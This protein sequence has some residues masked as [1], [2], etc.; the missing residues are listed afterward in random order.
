MIE[1]TAVEV[2]GEPT[3]AHKEL[4]GAF[5]KWCTEPDWCQGSLHDGEYFNNGS[6]NAGAFL[7]DTQYTSVPD[8]LQHLTDRAIRRVPMRAEIKSELKEIDE[9]T[10]AMAKAKV[11]SSTGMNRVSY[12]VF[13]NYPGN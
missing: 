9:F 12:N 7:R 1:G 13:K 10:E 8:K 2:I 6:D 3:E 4:T 5:C 11:N